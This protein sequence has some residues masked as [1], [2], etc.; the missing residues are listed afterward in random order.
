MRVIAVS[1]PMYLLFAFFISCTSVHEETYMDI[2]TV[3]LNYYSPHEPESPLHLLFIHHSTGGALLAD[4][5]ERSGPMKQFRIYETHPNGGGLRSLLE[6]NNYIVHEASYGSVIGEETDICHWNRKFRDS[7]EEMLVTRQQDERFSDGT[8]NKIVIFK[9]CFPNSWITSE[10]KEP[11]DPDSCEKT[12]ANYKAAYHVLLKYFRTRPDTLFVVFTAPPLA[13]P[14]L[15]TKDK[16]MNTVKTIVGR[17][18]TVD[19]IGHRTR[20]FNNW[21]KDVENG[22]LKDYEL[23]NVVV[24]DYYDVLTGYGKSDWSLYPTQGGRDSHPSSV[25]QTKS[26]Q[27]FVPFLNRAVHRLGL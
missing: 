4:Y 23:N 7:M 8:K 10:G 18:D 20:S 27:T 3:D 15:F 11:G 2:H 6:K 13:E 5:G 1:I 19:K 17:P 14:F 26:A 25:G 21:L 16:I 24:F 22:W 9:S 12:T